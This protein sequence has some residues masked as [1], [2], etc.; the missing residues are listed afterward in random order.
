MVIDD[1]CSNKSTLQTSFDDSILLQKIKQ[2]DKEK[3]IGLSVDSFMK[4]EIISKFSS[5]VFLDEPLGILKCLT[6]SYSKKVRVDIF[7]SDY[8]Y[9][10]KENGERD[11]MIFDF[12]KEISSEI[13]LLYNDKLIEKVGDVKD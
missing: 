2:I 3:Y 13:D 12:R 6:L 9:I 5:H 7:V 10:K 8:K 4:N 1:N 11:W